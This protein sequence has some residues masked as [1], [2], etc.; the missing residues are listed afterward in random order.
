MDNP[1]FIDEENIWV[2]P[3]ED[4]DDYKTPDTSRIDDETLLIEPYTTELTSTLRLR[5]KLKR[6]KI[7]SLY[8]YLDVTGD[9]GLADL[10]RFV[11]KKILKQVILNY[12]FSMEII[13][14]NALLINVLVSF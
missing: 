12:F 1:R 6:D 5:Q 2:V 9:S 3:D 13:N 10:D 11:I 4:C 14:D 8:R 7:V